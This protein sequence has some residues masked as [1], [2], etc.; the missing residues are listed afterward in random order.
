LL[1]RLRVLLRWLRVLLRW[2]RITLL[3]DGL[4]SVRRLLLRGL[5]RMQRLWLVL[6]RLRFVVR[7]L[8]WQRVSLF[9]RLWRCDRGTGLQLSDSQRAGD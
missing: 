9:E 2:L 4:L 5:P 6:F 3:V 8:L 1:R 7:R